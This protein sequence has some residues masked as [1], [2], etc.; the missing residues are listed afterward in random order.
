MR[1]P[2]VLFLCTA[3]SARSVMAEAFPRRA[4]GDRFE[5]ASAGLAPAPVHPLTVRVMREVGIE[6]GDRE[7]RGVGD[8]L[9][10]ESFRYVVS[11]CEAAE[12][13][14]PRLWPF[15]P[16]FLSWPFQ[17][18]ADADGTDAE[19]LARFRWVRDQIRVRVEA[20]V[21]ELDRP[22]PHDHY[23]HPSEYKPRGAK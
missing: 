5:V 22:E 13:E 2:G 8:Y 19:R 1:K 9:G 20:W 3:N 7:P 10:R 6:V 17:D 21:R 23:I 14:C 15:A 18:P 16:T 4:A 12:R 11:V